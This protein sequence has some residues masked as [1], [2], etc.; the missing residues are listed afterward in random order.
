MTLME[1]LM[2]ATV[3]FI[4]LAGTLGAA[5]EHDAAEHAA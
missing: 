4:V 1:V 2:A 3:G 5:R